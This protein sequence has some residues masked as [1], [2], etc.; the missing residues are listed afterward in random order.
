MYEIDWRD[1]KYWNGFPKNTNNL[2]IREQIAKSNNRVQCTRNRMQ[3]FRNGQKIKYVV[4]KKTCFQLIQERS[5][6]IA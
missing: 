4:M 2:I 5:N 1:L 3:K 6:Q